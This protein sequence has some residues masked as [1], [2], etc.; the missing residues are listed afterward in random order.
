MLHNIITYICLFYGNQFANCITQY[1]FPRKIFHNITSMPDTRNV[2]LHSGHKAQLLPEF[3]AGGEKKRV[4]TKTSPVEPAQSPGDDTHA[5][6]KRPKWASEHGLRA[7]RGPLC[8]WVASLIDGST[9]GSG[10]VTPR[11]PSGRKNP[12]RPVPPSGSILPRLMELVKRMTN[13]VSVSAGI[14]GGAVTAGC[15]RDAGPQVDSPV[16]EFSQHVVF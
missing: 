9:A 16:F 6:A 15:A 5:L 4:E 1:C 14:L 7:E 3:L 11:Q 8:R 2:Q 13:D 10:P 12:G